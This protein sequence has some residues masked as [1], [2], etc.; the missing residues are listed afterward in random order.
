M[1]FVEWFIFEEHIITINFQKD[2]HFIKKKK[3][4]RQPEKINHLTNKNK[5]D[6]NQQYF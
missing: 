4:F 6:Y 5:T 1:E 3:K 2:K